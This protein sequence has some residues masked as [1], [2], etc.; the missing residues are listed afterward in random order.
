[1]IQ[2]HTLP[3]VHSR[4][5]ERKKRE[6]SMRKDELVKFVASVIREDKRVREKDERNGTREKRIAGPARVCCYRKYG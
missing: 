4:E 2:L 1:M 3:S 5:R 6:N